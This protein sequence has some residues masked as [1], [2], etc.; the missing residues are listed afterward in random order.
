MSS[1]GETKVEAELEQLLEQVDEAVHEDMRGRAVRVR[2]QRFAP[3]LRRQGFLPTSYFPQRFLQRLLSRGIRF[4]SC[5]FRRE[6]YRAQHYRH[7]GSQTR[8]AVVQGVP[9]LYRI[10]TEGDNL[11][12]LVDV[13]PKGASPRVIPTAAPWQ[14]EAEA[15]FRRPRRPLRAGPTR[16]GGSP[17]LQ[18]DMTRA[19]MASFL[20]GLWNRNPILH[21]LAR[22]QTMTG[23]TQHRE[24]IKVLED[25]QEQTG[26]PVQV[27]RDGTVQAA[28]GAGNLASLRS[29]PG[30][31]QIEEQVFQTTDTLMNEVRHELSY[32][33]AGGPGNVPRLRDSPFNAMNLLE[34]MIQ[35]HGRLPPPVA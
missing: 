33:Y 10:G 35:G 29:R 32:H 26:I 25:F 11:I 9:V 12:T 19:Q 31:L 23:Q 17:P 8:I 4:N 16:V 18:R 20:Q 6:F 28:R 5:T 14:G 15:M 34:W 13:L 1:G 27:M 21:R 22:A 30:V 24:L 3:H 2:K 7:L